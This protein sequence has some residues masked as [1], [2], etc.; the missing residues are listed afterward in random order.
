MNFCF[1]FCSFKLIKKIFFQLQ[2]S[3]YYLIRFLN[4]SCFRLLLLLVSCFAMLMVLFNVSLSEKV[5][6]QNQICQ[7]DCKRVFQVLIRGHARFSH[8]LIVECFHEI[9]VE[10]DVD[11]QK[12]LQYLQARYAFGH[13]GGHVNVKRSKRIVRV[14][15]RMNKVVHEAEPSSY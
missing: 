3:L 9:D 2:Q 7:V 10:R 12:H 6:K 11:G 4:R 1:V 13:E 5:N 15:E 14:H 8:R